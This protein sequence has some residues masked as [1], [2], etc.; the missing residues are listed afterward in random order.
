VVVDG[1]SA[2]KT[3]GASAAPGHF[4]KKT[5]LIVVGLRLDWP[6]FDYVFQ[7]I[8]KFEQMD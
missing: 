1:L 5:S 4:D 6:H 7:T 2:K 3:I 8:T